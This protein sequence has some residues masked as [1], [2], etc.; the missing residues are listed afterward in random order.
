M[1][2]GFL[3]YIVL[4]TLNLAHGNMSNSFHNQCFC[5]RAQQKQLNRFSYEGLQSS[6][7]TSLTSTFHIMKLHGTHWERSGPMAYEQLNHSQLAKVSDSCSLTEQIK[8]AEVGRTNTREQE[9]QRLG[10]GVPHD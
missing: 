4:G 5:N 2:C 6:Q 10:Y 7:V 8:V 9:S 1:C 3:N